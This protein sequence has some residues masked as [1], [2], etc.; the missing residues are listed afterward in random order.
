ME[1]INS[2]PKITATFNFGLFV[3]YFYLVMM[4]VLYEPELPHGAPI[5]KLFDSH[6]IVAIF[7]TITLILS[8]FGVGSLLIRSFWKRLVT[9]LFK[10]RKI[11]FQEALSILLILGLITI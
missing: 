7:L 2:S 11:E 8:A 5:D 9:D 1:K 4:E 3:F 6:P 10:V